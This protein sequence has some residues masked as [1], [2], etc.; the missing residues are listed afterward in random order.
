MYLYFEGKHVI[1]VVPP[2]DA[3]HARRHVERTVPDVRPVAHHARLP[4]DVAARVAPGFI[5]SVP[6]GA[7][8][9]AGRQEEAERG[10]QLTGGLDVVELQSL[11]KNVGIL[12]YRD[13]VLA[14]NYL[15]Q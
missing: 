2:T 6:A 12:S 13:R 5:E 15:C 10:Q 4:D 1:R 8:G 9:R 7:G 11:D 14:F 3:K